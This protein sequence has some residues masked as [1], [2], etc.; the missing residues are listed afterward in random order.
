MGASF[1]LG[2]FLGKERKQAA[3]A[4]KDAEKHAQESKLKLIEN[5]IVT[6]AQEA[7]PES[8]EGKEKYFMDQVAT[9]EELCRQG[10]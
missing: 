5:V 8:P 9:G 10:K 4:S 1:N 6:C 3:K 2:I 7:Y